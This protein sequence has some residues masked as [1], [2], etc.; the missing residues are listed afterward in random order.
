MMNKVFELIEAKNIFKLS[1]QNLKI[2]VHRDSY[3]HAIVKFKNGIT[4]MIIHDTDMNSIFG[5]LNFNE[6]YFKN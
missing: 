4:K 1:L 3:L 5:T 6:K 2:L